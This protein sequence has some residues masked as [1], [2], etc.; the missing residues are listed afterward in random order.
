[1]TVAVERNHQ[2]FDDIS[3]QQQIF[4]VERKIGIEG[5]R[6]VHK[7]FAYY[8]RIRGRSVESC[9]VGCVVAL[10]EGAELKELGLAVYT[11]KTDTDVVAH[12]CGAGS[13][14]A[15]KV[16][17]SG[18][19]C[20]A[21]CSGS[22]D[23]KYTASQCGSVDS[24]AL[25]S[26]MNRKGGYS[27]AQNRKFKSL[28]GNEGEFILGKGDE[29]TQVEKTAAGNGKVGLV[30]AD[31]RAPVF[32][33]EGES[34]TSHEPAGKKGKDI[35]SLGKGLTGRGENNLRCTIR[36]GIHNTRSSINIDGTGND[37][38]VCTFERNAGDIV[39]VNGKTNARND[40]L[41]RQFI[42]FGGCNAHESGSIEIP[43]TLREFLGSRNLQGDK[44]LGNGRCTG[45]RISGIEMRRSRRNQ[46]LE[47]TGRSSGPALKGKYSFLGARIIKHCK[48]IG[49][50]PKDLETFDICFRAGF[51]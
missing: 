44:I 36:N 28:T 27:L 12:N 3:F 35:F 23:F 46:A 34:H 1:M 42:A 17:Q 16:E 49:S 41:E 24:P 4:I 40:V 5:E 32:A 37:L 30:R 22:G 26:G 33:G 20:G 29:S 50:V 51:R 45:R 11:I 48:F 9:V 31:H 43:A 47:S 39:H 14:S 7:V 6:T 2:V 19:G 25:G 21:A 13:R 10:I 8:G 18:R 38:F 15:A